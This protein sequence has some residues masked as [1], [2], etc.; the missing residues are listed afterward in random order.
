MADVKNMQRFA[1]KCILIEL[2]VLMAKLFCREV[3]AAI[4]RGLG[5]ATMF[6]FLF[7]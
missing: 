7:L 2:A 1:S 6:P 4:S 3:Y 5:E